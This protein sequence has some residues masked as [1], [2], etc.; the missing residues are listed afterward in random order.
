MSNSTAR[1]TSGV[2]GRR[3]TPVSPRRRAQ[4]R[5]QWQAGR[6]S[7]RGQADDT[8]SSSPDTCSGVSSTPRNR[9]V[10]IADVGVSPR[11]W[12]AVAGG[13]APAPGRDQ[14]RPP[15]PRRPQAAAAGSAEGGVGLE[16][17]LSLLRATSA[18]TAVDPNVLV[19]GAWALGDEAPDVEVVGAELLG[20]EDDHSVM[21]VPGGR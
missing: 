16:P 14:R 3:L 13:C 8:R 1:T 11:A 4:G 12:D 19:A 15:P 20:R 21:V 7:G 10:R 9:Q 2:I 18:G 6:R 5:P 17:P